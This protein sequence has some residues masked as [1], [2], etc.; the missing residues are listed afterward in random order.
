MS[1]DDAQLLYMYTKPSIPQNN[2]CDILKLLSVF[3]CMEAALDVK[4][5]R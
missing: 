5:G 1:A 3:D 2:T 4:L